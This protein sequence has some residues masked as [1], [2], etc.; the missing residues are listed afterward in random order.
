MTP[1]S[2]CPNHAAITA[3]GTWRT[4]IKNKSA[5]RFSVGQLLNLADRLDLNF[6]FE[7]SLIDLIDPSWA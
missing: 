1:A 7:L 2:A 6:G 5:E 3:N 4:N